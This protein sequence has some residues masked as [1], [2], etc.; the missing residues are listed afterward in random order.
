MKQVQTQI[1]KLEDFVEILKSKKIISQDTDLQFVI[2]HR[3]TDVRDNTGTPYVK[4]VKLQK[5]LE[6]VDLLL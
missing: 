2:A 4:E 3:Y 1:I 6:V 5:T